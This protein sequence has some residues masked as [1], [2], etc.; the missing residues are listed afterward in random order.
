MHWADPWFV[1]GMSDDPEA[2]DLWLA[3]FR[4]FGGEA[5]SDAEF[6]YVAAIMLEVAPWAL[7]GDEIEWGAAAHR[8]RACS[9][10]LRPNGFLPE[11]FDERSDYGR[12]FAHQSR[13]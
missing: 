10:D 2:S 12:Y 7:A 6:L 9:L 4:Q 13:Q 3:I 8:M 1:T 5:S 11:A